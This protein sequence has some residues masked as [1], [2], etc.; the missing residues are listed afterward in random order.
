MAKLLDG[1]LVSK[2]IKKKLKIEVEELYQKYK[3]KPYLAAV[4]VGENEVS[5]TYVNYKILDCSEVGFKSLL[6]KL[7]KTISEIEFLTRIDELNHKKNLSG[8][9][10]QLPLPKHIDPEKVILAIDP[11]KDVDCFH[12]QNFGKMALEIETFF[13]A[14]PHGILFLLDYYK[15]STEGKHCVIVG[16]SKIVGKPMSILMGRK[17][18]PGNSTVTLVHSNTV[19]IKYYT[20]QAD[21]IIIALG[22]PN[23]LTADMVKEGVVIVDVGITRIEDKNHRKG[24]YLVGDVDFKEVEKKALW[25]T[26]VPGGVGPMTRSMLLKNTLQ[27]FKNTLN[28]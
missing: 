26:P 7:P 6:I 8:Y 1:I 28:N 5:K 19:N 23:F 22:I 24:Y 27:A 21:I 25:I 9:I 10:V 2:K 14:T 12:P 13:P 15:I 17:K 16:R 11:N 20:K 4:L 18:F 3:K